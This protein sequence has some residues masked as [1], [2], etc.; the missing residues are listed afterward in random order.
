MLIAYSANSSFCLLRKSTIFSGY[1]FMRYYTHQGKWGIFI[2][3]ATRINTLKMRL[4][5]SLLVVVIPVWLTNIDKYT[6]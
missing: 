5:S 3:S 1:V 2:A 6:K 4:F